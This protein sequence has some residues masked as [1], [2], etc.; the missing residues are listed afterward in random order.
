M[1]F[2]LVTVQNTKKKTVHFQYCHIHRIK[3]LHAI[4]ISN[5]KSKIEKE[6]IIIKS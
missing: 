2:D 6:I 5:N 1:R 3:K 4:V